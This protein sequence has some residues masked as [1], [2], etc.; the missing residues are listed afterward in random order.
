[1]DNKFEMKDI[2]EKKVEIK[3]ENFDRKNEDCKFENID[4]IFNLKKKFSKLIFNYQL[5]F[6]I[7]SFL[8]ILI[9]SFLLFKSYKSFYDKKSK[10]KTHIKEIGFNVIISGFLFSF[11]PVFI[12]KKLIPRYSIIVISIYYFIIFF[13]NNGNTYEDHGIYNNIGFFFVTLYFYTIYLSLIWIIKK[14]RN[15]NL[16]ILFI[17]ISLLIILFFLFILIHIYNNNFLNKIEPIIIIKLEDDNVNEILID[18]QKECLKWGYGLGGKRLENKEESL[19]N[20]N[21]CYMQYPNKCYRFIYDNVFDYSK[22]ENINCPKLNIN[23]REKLI[24]TLKIYNNYDFSSTYNFGYPKT[25]I[26]QSNNE[27]IITNFGRLVLS[28]IY[29]LDKTENNKKNPEISLSFDKEGKGTVKINIE[30]NETL[31]K[32]KRLKYEKIKNKIKYENIF[33]IYLDSLGRELFYRKLPK[34]RKIFENYY[35]DNKNK[36]KKATSFQFFKYQNFAGWTDIN[37]TP[38][39]YGKKFMETGYNIV[40]YYNKRGYISLQA[41]GDCTQT[42]FALFDW[43]VNTLKGF[44]FDYELIS[45][46]CDPNFIDLNDPYSDNNNKFGPYS[47]IR[48]CLYGKDYFE[49]IFEYAKQFIYQYKDQPKFMR[50]FFED[51]HEDTQEKIK[52]I[53]NS[54]SDFIQNIIDDYF[55]ERNLIIFVS[56]HGRSIH[57]FEQTFIA[58][59]GIIEKP[60]GVLFL[61]YNDNDN[62]YN[63]SGLIL[64]EQKFVTPYDIFMTMLL[65][66]DDINENDKNNKGQELDV[67]IDGMKRN[68]YTYDDYN[69]KDE[70]TQTFCR[71]INF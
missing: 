39:M 67:E 71:C 42:L 21:S 32:E 8:L 41:G 16:F 66:F 46:F 31:I 57:N 5:F 10:F 47:I 69:V 49:Y 9:S 40:D 13:F 37:V 68:C 63:K 61:I 53:D 52:Y 35:W 24:N 26:M 56:D 6:L 30:R 48:N 14:I 45:L 70:K 29:D 64:N 44:Y 58:D 3:N 54:L 15:K 28:N 43:N 19:K 38:M 59:D 36:L 51:A 65:N 1:M 62:Y 11:I 23:S 22:K 2:K 34:T 60:I 27:R 18:P 33:I 7:I 12:I 20:N 25:N 55:N 4:E 17:F 50:I